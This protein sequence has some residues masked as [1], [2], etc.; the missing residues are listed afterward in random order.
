MTSLGVKVRID[1][2]NEFCNL[3]WSNFSLNA[4]GHHKKINPKV[5]EYPQIPVKHDLFS[6]YKMACE[7]VN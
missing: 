3:T 1:F 5:N 7:R 4:E 2:L 6:C